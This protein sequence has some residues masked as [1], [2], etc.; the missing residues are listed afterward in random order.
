MRKN[1]Q[2]NQ[3]INS[4]TLKVN[5][6]N[7][8]NN[9]GK[10]DGFFVSNFDFKK[11]RNKSGKSSRSKT[12]KNTDR[13]YNKLNIPTTSD[14]NTLFRNKIFKKGIASKLIKNPKS[15]VEATNERYIKPR[16]NLIEI[17]KNYLSNNNR[18]FH[19][20]KISYFNVK[21]SPFL[22]KFRGKKEEWRKEKEEYFCGV[23]K[24]GLLVWNE[25]SCWE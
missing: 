1:Y 21:F 9:Y 16:I 25:G 10:S 20:N 22:V 17:Y 7:L 24:E 23:E 19:G 14:K 2:E 6:I 18:D 11:E 3:I 15:T 12:S 13:N 4:L 5:K 8:K